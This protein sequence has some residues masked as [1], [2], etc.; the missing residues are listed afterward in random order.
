MWYSCGESRTQGLSVLRGTVQQL[1]LHALDAIGRR[2]L[3]GVDYRSAATVN[4]QAVAHCVLTCNAVGDTAMATAFCVAVLGRARCCG[5]GHLA[6]PLYMQQN[7]EKSYSCDFR[8]QENH[9]Y[10]H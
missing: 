5:T 6:G 8:C 1:H 9:T 2:V 10:A 3:A 4:P 7:R